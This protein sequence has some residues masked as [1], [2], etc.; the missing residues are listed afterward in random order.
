[1]MIRPILAGAATR[2]PGLYS[3]LRRGTGGTNSAL[4]CYGLWIKHLSIAW[5]SGLRAVPTTIAELGPGDS[6][7]VGIAALLSGVD[8]YFAFDV[9]AHAR[10][11]RNLQVLD[12]LVNLLSARAAT[13]DKQGFPDIEPYVDAD[14]FPSHILTKECLDRSLNPDRVEAIR[15]TLRHSGRGPVDS[16]SITY[17]V[18]WDQAS[19]VVEGSVDM[20]YSHSV[21]EYVEDLASAYT[22]MRRWIKPN[23]FMSHQIDFS[24]HGLARQ[25]NGHWAYSDA[26]WWIVKGS[27][28]YQLN[29]QPHG[30]HVRQLQ[31]AGFEIVRDERY[32]NLSGLPPEKL[33]PRFR[34]LATDD[35][36]CSGALIQA[37]PTSSG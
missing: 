20:I 1:M 12:E 21:L 18:P 6:L 37:A 8:S 22:A 5:A 11:E 13:P 14:W 30:E 15:E 25:W 34:R 16:I 10:T 32:V 28:S 36:T 19:K 9:V 29:R 23:G 35:V 33:A 27:R 17:A 3:L 26:L 31:A 24:S 2:V 4:Y 7:G